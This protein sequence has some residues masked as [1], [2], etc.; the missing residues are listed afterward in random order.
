[1][2]VKEHIYKYLLEIQ[3]NKSSTEDQS[4]MEP[5]E[6]VSLIVRHFANRGVILPPWPS[7]Q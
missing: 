4:S 5:S 7:Y 3:T 2:L 6:I 1:M